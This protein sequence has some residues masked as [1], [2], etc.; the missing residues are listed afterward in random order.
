[1]QD[2]PPY[3]NLVFATT[4]LATFG[5]AVYVVRIALHKNKTVST[6]YWMGLLIWLTLTGWLASNQFFD[7]MEFS[8][9]RIFIFVAIYTITGL[10]PFLT[11][12]GRA[13]FTEMPITSLTYLHIIRIPVEI[14]L[15]WLF[16]EGKVPEKMTFEGVNYDIISGI[17]APFIA[18]FAV[19]PKIKYRLVAIIWNMLALVVLINIVMHAILSTPFF[20]DPAVYST[21]N[22]AVLYP[23]FVWLPCFVAPTVFL[24]HIISLYKLLNIK[25]IE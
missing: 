21:P 15:W 8:P 14:V 22:I 1:M 4:T 19:G 16:L 5:F 12:K 25:K 9:P 6:I 23:P 20:Y 3:I 2:I 7:D 10:S 18:I 13:F 17:T 24:A 11:K